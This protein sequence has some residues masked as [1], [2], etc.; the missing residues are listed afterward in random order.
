MKRT[1]RN[2]CYT[3]KHKR[4]VPGSRHISCAKPDQKMEGSMRAIEQRWFVYPTKFDPSYKLV[5][6]SN[7][8]ER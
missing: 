3:C 4:P 2:E 5:I 1:K 7:Y 6:C 8:K